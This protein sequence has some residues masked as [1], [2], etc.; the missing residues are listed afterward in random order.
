MF[1][2]VTNIF[3]CCCFSSSCSGPLTEEKVQYL[4]EM[5]AQLGLSKEKGDSVIKQART[6]IFGS[7]AAAEDGKW[8]LERIQEVTGKGGSIDGLVEEVTRRNI[9]RR[10]FERA[11]GDGTGEFNSAYMLQELPQTLQLDERK[12]RT[13]VAT[14]AA[15]HMQLRWTCTSKPRGV[16]H[17]VVQLICWK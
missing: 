16:C 10:E 5:R 9:Y 3:F 1:R 13:V 7:Q 14:C 4:D 8:T 12:V 15:C 2:L 6:E 11:L 17:G